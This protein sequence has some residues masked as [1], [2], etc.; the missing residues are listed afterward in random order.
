MK[1]ESA[2]VEKVSFDFPLDIRKQIEEEGEFHI[3]GY[4][5]TSDFDLQGDII[6]DDA[7]RSSKLDLIKNSTVLL[8]HDIKLPIGKVTKAEFDQHGLLIDVLISKTEPDVIQKIKEGVLNKFSI[9]G[10][11]LEREKKFMPELDRVV[12]VITRMSLVEVSLV[13]VPANPEAKAIG[14]YL[15]KALD[16]LDSHST[17][18]EDKGGKSMSEKP[19]KQDDLGL[20]KIPDD[21]AKPGAETPKSEPAKTEEPKPTPSSDPSPA[22][23]AKAGPAPA[24]PTEAKKQAG[25]VA[26]LD[27]VWSLL[28]KLIGMGG[29]VSS[30]ALQIKALLTLMMG[31]KGFQLPAPSHSESAPASALSK[32]ETARIIADEVRKQIDTALKEV[33]VIRKGL[34]QPE[35]EPT[36]LKKKLDELPLEQ[37]LKVALALEGH[38]PQGHSTNGRSTNGQAAQKS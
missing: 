20:E 13:S 22:E 32:E 38:S 19:E 4:A 33:P 6:T 27:L 12:N 18:P 8:N 17:E 24:P 5:A 21:E 26:H 2:M 36:D 31:D 30:L 3:V 11:V 7:L 34:V 37:K 14:W 1:N 9:R 28:D 25:T 10:Q 23:V 29:E 16:H 15:K 35:E